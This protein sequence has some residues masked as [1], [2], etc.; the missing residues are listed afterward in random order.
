MVLSG[1]LTEQFEV[2]QYRRVVDE[3]QFKR[4]ASPGYSWLQTRAL[5]EMT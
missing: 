3:S 1:T 4:L 2:Q 5:F